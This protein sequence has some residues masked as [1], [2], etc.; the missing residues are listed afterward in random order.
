MR[1][2]K[3]EP[4][5]WSGLDIGSRKIS[6]IVTET[7][8]LS[9][10]AQVIA[11]GSSR[12]RGISRGE[13]RNG[14]LVV[15]SIRKA[16][17]EVEKAYDLNVRDTFLSIGPS[18]AFSF[19][20]GQK[21]SLREEG[22]PER[23]VTG[24]D[25]KDIL[26]EVLKTARESTQDLLLHAIPLTFSVDSGSSM[27]DP[28]GLL[29][30]ELAVEVLFIGLAGEEVRKSVSCAEK[31]GLNVLGVVHKSIASAFGSLS[32]EEL[33]DG[34]VVVDIGAG[35]STVTYARE[36]LV[37]AMAVFPVGG[38]LVTQDVAELLSI[39]ASKAEYLKREVSLS[40]APEDL[41]D[42]L[43]F[44]M[45]GEPFVVTVRNVLD[46]VSP[47]IEEIFFRF[48][49]PK[50]EEFECE[51]ALR[52]IVFSGGV[53]ESPGFIDLASESFEIP[54]RLGVPVKESSLPLHAR[55]CEFSSTVGIAN[56]L[57][58]RK[59]YPENLLK[60]G[61]LGSG[62]AWGLERTGEIMVSNHKK[63]EAEIKGSDGK[64][65]MA[66]FFDALKNAF[67]ELF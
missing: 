41:H 15:E 54:V 7:D 64:S 33:E 24:K 58:E 35:T 60:P 2:G 53:A 65:Q 10:E 34:A 42:E 29:G 50:I 8:P 39:P 61:S 62:I 52:T 16:V 37:R 48:I 11:I 51:G 45:G 27:K 18:S 6:L 30:S 46:I 14:D 12:S 49:V 21:L 59:N 44:E 28:T 67:K 5:I 31:A 9:Q 23:T 43:E 3:V 57:L 66:R 38:D 1:R 17:D 19:V 36:G 40:E 63:G 22:E 20:M 47:R 25:I 4:I 13:I 55:G 32:E 56:Y 26:K